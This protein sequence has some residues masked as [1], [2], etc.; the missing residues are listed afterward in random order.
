[1]K[2]S[3][4]ISLGDE[5]L[6]RPKAP[7]RGKRAQPAKA[8]KQKD[9]TD[10]LNAE[11]KAQKLRANDTR[12][13]LVSHYFDPLEGGPVFAP[14]SF[15]R[16][17][18]EIDWRFSDPESFFAW[19][20]DRA[21]KGDRGGAQQ[22]LYDFC[23]YA[24]HSKPI[25]DEIIGFLLRCFH[26]FSRQHMGIEEA[27]YLKP[28][29]NR[30]P[31][32]REQSPELVVAATYWAMLRYD[33]SI[34]DA[35][36]LIAKVFGIGPRAIRSYRSLLDPDAREFD[37]ARAKIDV[38]EKTVTIKYLRAGTSCTTLGADTVERIANEKALRD[39]RA[40]VK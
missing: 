17:P 31:G 3:K 2:S 22:I 21:C 24:A 1:M 32:S 13:K 30:A 26:R 39:K 7:A 34:G 12:A 11:R 33:Y 19:C 35:Q 18:I 23:A 14:F 8:R 16:E 10:A 40:A 28:P 5:L 6:R 29:P 4:P 36:D 15:S 37:R 9:S 38:S 20:A 27:L 25:P